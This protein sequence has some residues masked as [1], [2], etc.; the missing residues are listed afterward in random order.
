MPWSG[1]SPNQTP[2]RN[3][4]HKTGSTAWQ[5]TEAASRGIESSDQDTHDQDMADMIG[6]CLKRDGGNKLTANV[7]VGGF[8]FTNHADPSSA[9]DVATKGYVDDTAASVVNFTARL[10]STVNVNLTTDVDAGST[11][12]GTVLVEADR[13]LLKNQTDASENGIYAVPAAAGTATRVTDMDTWTETLGAIVNITAGSTQSGTSWRSTANSGGTLDTTDLSFVAHGT[14]ITLPLGVASGGT[15]NTTAATAFAA[16]KQAATT[17][18]TGVVELAT[19]TEAITGTDTDRA[20]T[21]EALAGSAEPLG[22]A[23]SVDTKTD[24]YELVLTDAGRILEMNAATAKAFTI[25]ANATVAFSTNTY[26][27]F[28]RYGAGAV[29]VVGASGVTLNGVSQGTISIPVQYG[30]IQIYKRGTNEWVS[31]NNTA[32]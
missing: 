7:D 19:T 29:T 32:V 10:A 28:V 3:T 18:A 26:V 13:I 14:S 4:G 6:A 27:N 23:R 22:K 25:P 8:K 5:E 30:G 20:I 12:D 17:T 21:P 11:F 2:L 15:G 24:N 31:P 9:S 1:S 16:L